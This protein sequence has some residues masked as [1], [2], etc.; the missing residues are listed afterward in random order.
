MEKSLDYVKLGERVRTI[1][2]RNGYSQE[3]LSELSGISITHLSH[4]E[5]ANTKASL[6]KFVILA[7]ALEVTLDDFFCDSLTQATIPYINEITELAEDCNEKEIRIF[8][9]TLKALKESYRSEHKN[10]ESI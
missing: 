6:E 4:I 10:Q 7:N 9:S 5:C 2:K 1:R 8:C 3:D